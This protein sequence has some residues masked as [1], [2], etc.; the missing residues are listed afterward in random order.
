MKIY[1][2]Y[3]NIERNHKNLKYNNQ[4]EMLRL[5][6]ASWKNSGFDPI[7]LSLEDAKK[8]SFYK[9][10]V[11]QLKDLH[12]RIINKPINDYGLSCYVRWMAYATQ[13][14]EYFYVSDYDCINNGLKPIINTDKLHLMDGVCPCFAS[15]KPDQFENLCHLFI[16]VTT[17]RIKEMMSIKMTVYQDQQFFLCNFTHMNNSKSR[18]ILLKKNKILLTIDR[19]NG[20][21]SFNIGKKHTGKVLHISHDLAHNLQSTVKE[22]EKMPLDDVRILLMKQLV[23]TNA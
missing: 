4:K 8:H 13:Y 5:W 23:G 21:G 18:D 15:G 9:E 2:Y 14:D 17:E 6:K 7:V 11:D 12:F 10:F 20:I 22:F 19:T 1:T 3:E 16:D